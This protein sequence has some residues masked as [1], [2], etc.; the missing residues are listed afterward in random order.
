MIFSELAL[1]LEKLVVRQLLIEFTSD[2]HRS[3]HIFS[4]YLIPGTAHNSVIAD[5]YCGPSNP[6]VP[7]FHRLRSMKSLPQSLLASKIK[8]AN[9]ILL[10]PKGC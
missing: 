5:S 10:S 1:R 4:I 8:A 7:A 6:I 3:Y 9:F 2:N